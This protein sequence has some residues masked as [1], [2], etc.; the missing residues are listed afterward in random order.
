MNKQLHLFCLAVSMLLASLTVS[1]QPAGIAVKL[2]S[3][4]ITPNNV[5]NIGY[6]ITINTEVTNEDSS[7]YT[8]T[9]DFGLRNSNFV[10]N[11]S[12]VFNKPWYSGLQAITLSGFETVPAI[13]SV[14]IDAQYFAPGPDVVVVW[15]ISNKP[16]ADSVLIFI[17]VQNPSSIEDETELPF[18]YTVQNNRLIFSYDPNDIDFKQ[19]RI[20][21]ITGRMP[22]AYM[23]SNIVEVALGNLPR[24]LYLCEILTRDNQ[25]KTIKFVL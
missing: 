22:I 1:A 20:F 5:A 4:N 17:N 12:N 7:T 9:L 23:G 21:D 15:P 24:G 10:I 14:E 3:Y 13:F 11:D 8:G 2:L 25:R 16:I 19:V 6:T 18:A